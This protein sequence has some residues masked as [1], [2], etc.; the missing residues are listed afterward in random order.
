MS[1]NAEMLAPTPPAVKVSTIVSEYGFRTPPVTGPPP[2]TNAEPVV[3]G[4]IVP[5]VVPVPKN[6]FVMSSYAV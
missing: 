2:V 5:I 3:S 1:P 4:P 6:A